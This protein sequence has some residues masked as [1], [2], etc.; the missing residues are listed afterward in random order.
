MSVNEKI[1]RN[2][3]TEEQSHEWAFM[4]AHRYGLDTDKSNVFVAEMIEKAGAT[5]PHR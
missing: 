5:V 3:E 2:A 1:A 4:A